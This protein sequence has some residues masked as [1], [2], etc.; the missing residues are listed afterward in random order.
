MKFI[1]REKEITFLKDHLMK[2]KVAND[3]WFYQVM[4]NTIIANNKLLHQA[5]IKMNK[6][7]VFPSSDQCL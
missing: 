4:D 3:F 6:D 1:N 5:M 7:N 2:T